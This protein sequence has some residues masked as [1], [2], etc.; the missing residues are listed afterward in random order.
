MR[1]FGPGFLVAAAFIG[2]GTVTTASLAGAAYGFTLAW[3]VLAALAATLVLQEMAGRLGA[4]TGMDLGQALRASVGLPAVILALTA[5]TFGNAAYQ[6]GNLT[7]ASLGIEALLGGPRALWVVV[8][9]LAAAA[10]LSSGAYRIV[11]RALIVLVA[12]M[13]VVFI[14]TAA[15]IGPDLVAAAPALRPGVPAGAGLT[16]LALIGTTVVP[17]NLFLHSAAAREKWR[18]LPTA[19]ALRYARRDSAIAIVL[20]GIVTLAVLVTA[21]PLYLAAITPTGVADLAS[22]LEPLLGAGAK[23]LFA[24]G[25]FAAGLTSAITAP[26]AAAWATCGLLG[27]PTELR[28]SRFRLVGLGIIVVG[29]GFAVAGTRPLQAILLAQ[30][31]NGLLLPII[32]VFLLWVMNRPALLGEA[33]NGGFANTAGVVVTLFSIFVGLSMLY[34]VFIL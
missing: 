14:G 6:S 10:L 28:S 7:G 9:A 23:W 27:W 22:Q 30:A 21:V 19:D 31:A 24:V 12:V 16:V 4:V 25:L 18:G 5:I 29:A 2:P 33:R 11:E 34:R 3:A 13:S 8:C 32:A 26:L 1:R 20:G 15:M 17:Y